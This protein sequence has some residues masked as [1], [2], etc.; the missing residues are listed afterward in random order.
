[1]LFPCPV[2]GPCSAPVARA[3]FAHENV[4]PASENALQTLRPALLDQVPLR[5]EVGGIRGLHTK[6]M[7]KGVN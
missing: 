6:L 5:D 1:M 3:V 4:A 2:F 7:R